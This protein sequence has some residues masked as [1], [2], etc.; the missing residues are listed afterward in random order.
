MAA[1]G[2]APRFLPEHSTSGSVLISRMAIS[3]AILAWGPLMAY[4]MFNIDGLSNLVLQLR[5]PAERGLI[6]G[7]VSLRFL[8][9]VLCILQAAL[10]ASIVFWRVRHESS[11]LP[12]GGRSMGWQLIATL[13]TVYVVASIAILFG[14]EGL[15]LF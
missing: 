5:E 9:Q 1:R 13:C 12:A 14:A 2:L 7:G 4:Q 15:L 6:A 11:A 10:F 3:L 8:V